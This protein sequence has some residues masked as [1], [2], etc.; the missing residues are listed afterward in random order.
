M[1]E[2]IRRTII[3][4]PFSGDDLE[5]DA[6]IHRTYAVDF[7]HKRIGGMID[8]KEAAEQA[9]WKAMQTKRFAYLIY[10]DQYGC[11]VFNKVGSADLTPEY[12][13]N[14][15]PAMIEDCLLPDDIVDGVEE[16]TF[17]MVDNDSVRI[18]CTVRTIYGDT[19]LKGVINNE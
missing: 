18:N 6:I 19:E 13:D 17:E 10:D 14:D 15:I 4:A 3:D 9:I 1:S 5:N 11:D 7:E 2:E 16:I 8:G 12:L